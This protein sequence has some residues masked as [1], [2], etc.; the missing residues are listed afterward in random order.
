MSVAQGNRI[1]PIIKKLSFWV[2]ISWLFCVSHNTLAQQMTHQGNP[3]V[4][5]GQSK[6]TVYFELYGQSRQ[7]E[8]LKSCQYF[9][10]TNR[11]G[12]EVTYG[13]WIANDRNGLHFADYVSDEG[14][15]IRLEFRSQQCLW[16]GEDIR[17]ANWDRNTDERHVRIQGIH[18]VSG[19]VFQSLAPEVVFVENLAETTFTVRYHNY[20][21]QEM[22][23]FNNIKNFDVFKLNKIEIEKISAE[24]DPYVYSG[25]RSELQSYS[26]DNKYV[27]YSAIILSKQDWQK[28]AEVKELLEPIKT[29]MFL[30]PIKYPRFMKLYR[31]SRQYKG[32]LITQM[33]SAFRLES[34]F[35]VLAS[36]YLGDD[37]IWDFRNISFSSVYHV[38]KDKFGQFGGRANRWI[39]E[40]PYRRVKFGDHVFDLKNVF[41]FAS[42]IEN[43]A[44]I[45]AWFYDPETELLI[46]MRNIPI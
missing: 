23:I 7:I 25:I 41:E 22:T 1:I 43:K 32:F 16:E 40:T 4:G 18:P 8:I 36:P 17:V 34:S 12:D 44:Q 35:V 27:R 13:L 28:S 24:E 5:V 19:D 2:G 10:G 3:L 46:R 11:A 33:L 26:G 38:H 45:E 42:G 29:P 21:H 15:G 30:D 20:Y 31:E 39:Q 9:R 37:G 14:W 6:I